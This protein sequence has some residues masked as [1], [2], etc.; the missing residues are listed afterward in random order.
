MD[1][2]KTAILVDSCNDVPEEYLARYP[3]YR[4]PVKIIYRDREYDDR[5][6]ITPQEVYDRLEEEVPRTSLPDEGAVRDAFD[7]ILADGYDTVLCVTISGALSGTGNVVR[8]TAEQY[9]DRL[10]IFFV[11]TKN[12]GLGS[13]MQ[14]MLAGKLLQEG[15][16]AER[17][18]EKVLE[19]VKASR[20]FFCLSTLEYLAKGGR[21]GKVS[22]VLG[23][24]LHL[25]PI[26]TCNREGAYIVASKVRGRARAIAEMINL[27][28]A[29]AGRHVRYAL[30]VVQ[31]SA[32][33]ETQGV[34]AEIRR[35]L[36]DCGQ[37]IEGD[38]S[39]AL[40]VHTGPGLI[41]IFV[42]A[43]PA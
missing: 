1:D 38:V 31:G 6:D 5:V 2:H 14:A 40:V 27:A 33:E 43:L 12:I 26:I 30:A 13:G 8:L 22:A 24:L 4:V 23:S 36:P 42:Q 20:I 9:Q 41:G 35:R 18:H 34:I 32:K 28:A 3:M 29:E 11:D 25:K 19:S 7:R 37:I 21:I 10:R 15:E 16:P 17:I 39:P